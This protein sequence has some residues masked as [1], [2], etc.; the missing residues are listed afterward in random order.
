MLLYFSVSENNLDTDCISLYLE[1]ASLYLP[2]RSVT[3]VIHVLAQNTQYSCTRRLYV[4]EELVYA[5]V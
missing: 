5:D 2:S 4:L 1:A 3:V